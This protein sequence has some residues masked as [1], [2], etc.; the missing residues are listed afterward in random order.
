M[1]SNEKDG[2]CYAQPKDLAARVSIARDFVQRFDYSVPFVIDGM[3]DLALTAYS[4]WPE[5]LYAIGTDRRVAYKGG[6]GP[7]KFDP[8]ELAS[9]LR[10]LEG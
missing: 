2:V 6:I 10:T 7:F 9:W 8:D 5:R 4:A 1:G 3:D